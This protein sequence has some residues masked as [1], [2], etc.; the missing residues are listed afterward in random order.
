MRFF[1]DELASPAPLPPL[2]RMCSL[3]RGFNSVSSRTYRLTPAERRLYVSDYQRAVLT[4]DINGEYRVLLKDKLLFNLATQIFPDL[5]IPAHGVLHLGTL[6]YARH[7]GSHDALPY[8]ENLLE[9]RGKLVLRPLVGGGGRQIFFVQRDAGGYSVNERPL[10]EAE[11]ATW[12]RSLRR[13]LIND[14]V[15]QHP[16]IAALHE[17]TTNT[18]RLLTMWDAELQRPFVAAAALRIGTGKSYPV[19]NGMAGG[20]ASAIDLGTGRVSKAISSPTR[21]VP[22]GWHSAH[23]ETGATIEGLEIPHWQP[24]TARLLE[25]CRRLPYLPY[26]GWDL[27]VTEA[28]FRLIEGNH[29]P[30]LFPHQAHAPL[31]A[32]PRVRRFFEAYGVGRQPTEPSAVPGAPP[33][34]QAA[35]P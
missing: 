25:V 8:V 10:G 5:H 24:I 19:D 20:L 26:V 2:Q 1:G 21:T 35:S 12:L 22:L 28:G 9:T 11:F 17:R 3:L 4:P 27:I 7:R 29:Y 30:G 16:A 33:S 18:L 34:G 31:L 32:D 23:P 14:F 15:R 6:N 13:N